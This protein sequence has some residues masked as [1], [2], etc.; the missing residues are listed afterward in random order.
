MNVSRVRPRV[1]GPHLEQSPD[2]RSSHHAE[3]HGTRDHFRK[4]RDNFNFHGSHLAK[5]GRPIHLDRA[6]LQI[7]LAQVFGNRGHPVLSPRPVL[8]HHQGSG[9]SIDKMPH[10]TQLDTFDIAYR[11]ADQISAVVLPLARWRQRGPVD[12]DHRAAQRCGRITIFRTLQAR[13]ELV[14]M[15]SRLGY[16]TCDALA[17]GE[18]QGPLRVVQQSFRWIGVGLEVHPPFDAERGANPAQLNPSA[19][20]VACFLKEVTSVFTRSDGCAP[21]D[22]Q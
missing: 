16:F 21:L 12:L 6:G 7:N 2:Y 19:Q 4:Q 10:P 18:T 15:R 5:I 22:T 20:A 8:H 3:A 11:Q 17:A 13:D 1:F 9:R 14:A